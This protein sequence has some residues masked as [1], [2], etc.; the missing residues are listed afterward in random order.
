MRPI[1]TVHAGE[2][3]VADYIERNL[4]KKHGLRVWVPSKDDGIDL[5]VTTGDCRRTVSLQVKFSKCFDCERDYDASGW[6]LLSCEKIKMSS[7]DYWVFVLPKFK[8]KRTFSDC[9]YFVITPKVLLNRMQEIHDISAKY[10]R[11]RN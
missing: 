9:C 7:A 5:L 11:A 2:F 4:A 10:R 8:G 3:L 1:F 6:W